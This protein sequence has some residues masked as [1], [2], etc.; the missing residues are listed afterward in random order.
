MSSNCSG[1]R[2]PNTFCIASLDTAGTIKVTKYSCLIDSLT[3]F[4]DWNA[5][6]CTFTIEC[7]QTICSIT[8]NWRQQSSTF[9]QKAF[10]VEQLISY[11]YINILWQVL[12]IQKSVTT[13]VQKSVTT[14][15]IILS[16]IGCAL[17]QFR[18]SLIDSFVIKH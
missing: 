10:F 13:V 14:V 15:A 5:N 2:L 4:L 3:I 17:A 7:W 12:L 18:T 16:I 9:K 1:Q 8:N 11:W 6:Y